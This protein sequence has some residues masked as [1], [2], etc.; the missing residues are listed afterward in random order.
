MVPHALAPEHVGWSQTHWL[1]GAQD[2]SVPHPPQFTVRLAPQLSRA[3]TDP[4]AALR[5]WQNAVSLS[6]VHEH[7]LFEHTSPAPPH[8][9]QSRVL[10]QA[11]V[12]IPH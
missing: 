2:W 6:A 1:P 3:V 5:R 9:P 4:H 11:L 12:T 7:W 10:P 8:P